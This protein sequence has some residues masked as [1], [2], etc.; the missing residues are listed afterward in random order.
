MGTIDRKRK[1]G[2][3]WTLWG[4]E[5][6]LF[7]TTTGSYCY[8]NEEDGKHGVGFVFS[9]GVSKRVVQE[10]QVNNRISAISLNTDPI[11]FGIIQAYVSQQGRTALEKDSF[12]ERLQEPIYLAKYGS[13]LIICRDIN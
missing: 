6:K 2:G 7:S 1:G 3:D 10:D 5:T 13:L 9:P 4:K 8:S 12:Y 11:G